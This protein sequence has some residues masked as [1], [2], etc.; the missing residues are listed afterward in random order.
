MNHVTIIHVN[1]HMN[2]H[3]I[4]VDDLTNHVP[5][6]QFG[7]ELSFEICIIS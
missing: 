4:V 2:H 7:G 6:N 5:P 3:V 1:G